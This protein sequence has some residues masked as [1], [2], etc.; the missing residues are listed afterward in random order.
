MLSIKVIGP[1]QYAPAIKVDV[2]LFFK[3][4]LENVLVV[5]LKPISPAFDGD[6]GTNSCV[7]HLNT[8]NHEPV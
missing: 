1:W 5:V 8:N 4:L 3:L 2:F 6:T 7:K